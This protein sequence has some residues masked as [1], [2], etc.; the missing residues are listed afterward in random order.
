M[1]LPRQDRV[2]LLGGTE[3]SPPRGRAYASTPSAPGT[4]PSPGG[5]IAHK[6]A[7]VRSNAA[8][9]A[10]EFGLS[11]FSFIPT[12]TRKKA[13]RRR[14]SPQILCSQPT[15]PSIAGATPSSRRLLGL[16]PYRVG[17][18]PQAAGWAAGPAGPRPRA[19]ALRAGPQGAGPG[20]AARRPCLGPSRQ[21]PPGPEA[22]LWPLR[23]PHPGYAPE[24]VDSGG[25]GKTPSG[26]SENLRVHRLPKL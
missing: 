25:S 15:N 19:W 20:L 17:P 13:G 14:C 2:R 8:A 6:Q 1:D 3:L 4:E 24:D 12:F 11:L 5:G 22:T 16:L 9:L 26:P 21:T 23:P 18:S 7:L 10:C